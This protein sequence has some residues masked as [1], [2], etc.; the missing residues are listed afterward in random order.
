MGFC[1]TALLKL[2][3]ATWFALTNEIWVEVI[4]VT[5]RRKLCQAPNSYSSLSS[6]GW[7]GSLHQL[8]YLSKD[9]KQRALCQPASNLQCEQPRNPYV[10]GHWD[11]G[12]V[13]LILIQ[14]MRLRIWSLY[15]IK[16]S[17]SFLGVVCSPT[18]LQ[19][20]KSGF[21]VALSLPGC[22]AWL[23]PC[24]RT[25]CCSPPGLD[26]H[27][28]WKGFFSPRPLALLAW[29]LNLSFFWLVVY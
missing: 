7:T 28:P 17:L 8:C 15:K 3:V 5:S 24:E 21:S 20:S 25:L 27:P 2:G 4:W 10:V 11:F 19:V 22:T 14:H 16:R 18:S 9:G 13:Q 23:L 12:V 29:T 26:V 6:T 1:F